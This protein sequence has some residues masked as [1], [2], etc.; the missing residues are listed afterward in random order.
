MK[1][2]VTLSNESASDSLHKIGTVHYFPTEIGHFLDYA[3]LS[4]NPEI[5]WTANCMVTVPSQGSCGFHYPSHIAMS[6]PESQANLL[7][8]SQY[9]VLKGNSVQ[10]VSTLS[11][12][13]PETACRVWTISLDHLESGQCGSW[14]LDEN[15]DQVLGILIA[16]CPAVSEAYIL[17]MWEIVFDIASKGLGTEVGLP[18]DIASRLHKWIMTGD[19]QSLDTRLA[20][21]QGGSF[22]FHGEYGYPKLYQAA[23]M[24]N[25]AV[26]QQLIRRGDDPNEG[27][28]FLTV[29]PLDEAVRLQRRDAVERLIKGGFDVSEG[30]VMVQQ[31]PLYVAIIHRHIDVAV[32]LIEAGASTDEVY[33]VVAQPP[34]MT[35]MR[36]HSL[37][38]VQLLLDCGADTLQ[39]MT[40]EAQ[41]ASEV[42]R[43]YPNER[44]R[45]AIERAEELAKSRNK[46][47][48]SDRRRQ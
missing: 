24:G 20:D 3:L 38:I 2:K 33:G 23:E 47:E 13:N 16:A 43:D 22:R 12:A 11:I 40:G 17:P 7:V 4:L 45:S 9:G 8:P 46:Q 34:L 32:A 6:M 26:V 19:A 10:S 1:S 42:E 25:L 28:L 37:E 14:V 21:F 27:K 15:G 48:T 31:S 39:P 44:L 41:P 5:S 35:A 30:T 18:E 29:S 36:A